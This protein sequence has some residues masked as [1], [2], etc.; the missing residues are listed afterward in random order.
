MTANRVNLTNWW[1]P[2]HFLHLT[3]PP[4]FSPGVLPLSSGCKLH[5]S[6]LSPPF[7]IH[8]SSPKNPKMRV[9]RLGYS[10]SYQVPRSRSRWS[11]IFPNPNRTKGW[12]GWGRDIEFGEISQGPRLLFT[13]VPLHICLYIILVWLVCVFFDIL[14]FFG[15]CITGK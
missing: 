15:G 8:A 3:D 13:L 10:Q 5:P 9:H 7:P 12:V 11:P 6:K 1:G 4:N 14:W 2:N